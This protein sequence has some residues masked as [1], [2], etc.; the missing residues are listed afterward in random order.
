MQ[1]LSPRQRAFCRA[2]FLGGGNPTSWARLAGYTD[3]KNGAIRGAAFRL[4]HNKKVRLAM[5]ELAEARL[6]VEGLPEAVSAILEITRDK[7][8][9]QRLPAALAILNRTG[10]HEVV[11]RREEVRVELSVSEMFA[12]LI[13]LGKRPEEVL[14][15]LP[16]D[17]REAVLA[18]LPA[19]RRA[20]L[21]LK[22]G[23]G[24]TYE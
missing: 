11:E 4:I 8:H 24:G 15:N 20:E 12:E 16:A 17:E 21:E 18:A 19:R 2:A 3:N 14:A 6:R 22:K 5:R 9:R 7:Q 13:T 10:L 1:A 23:K